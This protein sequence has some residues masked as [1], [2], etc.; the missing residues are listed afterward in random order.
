MN[1]RA[2][3]STETVA[4]KMTDAIHIYQTF[5]VPQSKKE[6]LNCP[7]VDVSGHLDRGYIHGKSEMT[8]EVNR[9]RSVSE[10]TGEAHS[11]FHWLKRT[12]KPT[13]IG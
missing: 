5:D 7:V 13:P 9:S 11:A 10:L 2:K 3:Y 4:A 1:F 6:H 8:D 12:P